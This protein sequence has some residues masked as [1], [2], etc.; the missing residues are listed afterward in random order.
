M[1]VPVLRAA[2]EQYPDTAFTMLSQRRFAD[3]FADMPCNVTFHGADLKQQSL[4]EIVSGLGAYDGVADTHSVLRSLYVRAA[5]WCKGARVAVIDKGRRDKRLLTQGKLRTPLKHTTERYLEVF[6]RLGYPVKLPASDRTIQSPTPLSG[7]GIA[8]FAAHQGKIYPLD[9]M[10]RVVALLSAQGEHIVLFGGGKKEQE[11]LESWAEKYPGAESIAGR[12]TLREELE[13]MRRLRVMIT[14]DSGNMHLASLTGTRVVSIW[15]AT[16][17]Y[18]GF[19][20]HGQK[21]SDC[22]QRDLPC[23]P[24][25]IYGNKP[26]RFGDYRCMDIAPEVIVERVNK[27]TEH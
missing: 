2:A 5:M 14:M 18:A 24:C 19:L 27:E 6:S 23:R 11:V 8:P 4:H 3:L 15:G 16:H 17:P 20:G 13:I 21:E 12:K 9:R 25:S 7:I 1:L 26:C 22:V 10:E